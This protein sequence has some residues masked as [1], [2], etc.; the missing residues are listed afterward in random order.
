LPRSV[1][2]SN[3]GFYHPVERFRAIVA[4]FSAISTDNASLFTMTKEILNNV[5]VI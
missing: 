2:P 4:V 3:D 5:Q 1:D